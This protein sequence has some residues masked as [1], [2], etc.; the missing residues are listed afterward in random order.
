VRLVLFGPPGAG[1][2]TQA[3]AVKEK[4][5]I[6][7]IS[8]GEMLRESIAAGTPV[9][10]KA[11]ALVDSGSLVP[12]EVVGELVA[13]RLARRD[14]RRGFLLDGFPRTL[15]Q[16]TILEVVL[17]ART[18]PLD[19]VVKINLSD[20][21]VVRRLSGRRTCPSCGASYHVAFSPPK[22][23]GLCDACGGAL[24]HRDDDREDVIRK[25]LTIYA[26]QT[27]PLASHYGKLGLLKEVDGSGRI[28]EVRSRIF[29]ALGAA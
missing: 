22:V 3:A 12:D 23:D 20:D 14:A 18:E 9:G 25:R 24:S 19:A 5:G 2:G 4:F 28:E 6:P 26:S 13:E 11:K 15:R 27:A 29:K 7:H 8:T 17:K 21:E 16:A 1:K 10:V